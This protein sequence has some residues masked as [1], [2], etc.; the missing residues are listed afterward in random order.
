MDYCSSCRR[1]L[2][3]ALVCPGCGAYAPD[4]DPSAADGRTGPDAW[5]Y[6]AASGAWRDGNVDG[7]V[8]DDGSVWD[9][10]RAGTRE[11][12]LAYTGSSG[13]RPPT[14]GTDPSDGHGPLSTGSSDGH[15]TPDTPGTDGYQAPQQGRAAR[16]RQMARWKKNQ[17][18]AVVATAVALVGGGLTVA[19]MN[20]NST[21]GVQSATAPQ[22]TTMGGADGQAPTYTEP[23][24]TRHDTARSS[25][26]PTTPPHAGR[27]AQ[28]EQPRTAPRST[29][30]DPRTDAATTP[31]EL[32]KTTQPRTTVPNTVDTVTGNAGKSTSTVTEQT[33]PPAADTGDDTQQA[34]SPETTP[35][36]ASPTPAAT[37]PSNSGS[38]SKELCLLVI[39]LG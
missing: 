7:N 30:A 13:G 36:T 28:R 14:L 24:S 10:N 12:P 29:P 3:G 37:P 26:T 25:V 17:R 20:G 33:P 27:T 31:R 38:D 39:C 19:A 5:A 16:R 23:T 34:A 22:D 6:P 2:N 1:H 15:E 9:T 35:S 8:W 32:P 4:I 11:L 18:R 21:H